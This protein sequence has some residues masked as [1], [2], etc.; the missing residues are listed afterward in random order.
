MHGF[1]GPSSLVVEPDTVIV[2]FTPR[3]LRKPDCFARRMRR[4]ASSRTLYTNPRIV[5]QRENRLAE[6]VRPLMPPVSEQLGVKR[7]R[8]AAV[9]IGPGPPVVEPPT[10]DSRKVLRVGV[11]DLRHALGLVRLFLSQV[12]RAVGDPP[13]A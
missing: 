3:A 11:G 1:P 6:E 2:A 8:D 5:M 4:Q 12:E 9:A 7:G 13:V 10:D